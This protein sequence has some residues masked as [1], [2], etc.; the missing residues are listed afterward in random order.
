M[1]ALLRHLQAHPLP[2]LVV[3]TT[4]SRIE[5]PIAASERIVLGPLPRAD[6][7]ATVRAHARL[8]AATLEH[9]VSAARG[10]PGAAL[11]A[12]RQLLSTS[13]PPLRR[14]RDEPLRSK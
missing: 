13:A 9:I 8:P 14:T 1:L 3:A 6:M 12:L 10:N 4:L 5:L 11:S 7:A 2:L